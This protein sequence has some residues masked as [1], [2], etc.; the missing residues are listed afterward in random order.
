[1]RIVPLNGNGLLGKKGKNQYFGCIA[2]C[3]VD[4]MNNFFLAFSKAEQLIQCFGAENCERVISQLRNYR[5]G[6]WFH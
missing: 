6:D 2:I 3:N 5:A 4:L 1:M